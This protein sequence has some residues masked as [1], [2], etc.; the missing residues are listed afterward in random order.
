MTH[1]PSCPSFFLTCYGSADT[2]WHNKR[3]GK[4]FTNSKQQL[5]QKRLE[6]ARKSV[7][8]RCGTL[9]SG[10][11]TNRRSKSATFLPPI[12]RRLLFSQILFFFV[13]SH[14]LHLLLP[15]LL[16]IIAFLL[17]VVEVAVECVLQAV[18]FS[19]RPLFGKDI[20]R[21]LFFSFQRIYIPY[22]FSDHD[23]GA[24]DW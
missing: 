7:A 9:V 14:Q 1:F 22:S 20:G 15:F 10:V 17:L 19:D 21:L 13:F 18:C 11:G 6:S 24:A 4:Y 2:L 8:R 12:F 5:L 16:L 23:A 3:I